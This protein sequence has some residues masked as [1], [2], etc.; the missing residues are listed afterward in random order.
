MSHSHAPERTPRLRLLGLI[1]A[2]TAFL[3]LPCLRFGFV[4]D[5]PILI[6][7]N[8]R[9][10][11]WSF[12]PSYFQHH[13]WFNVS[14]TGSY[15]RPLVLVWLR[16][17]YALF[18]AKPAFWHAS[19]LLVHLAAVIL[20]YFLLHRTFQDTFT[21]AVATAV[22]ALHPAHIE[23]VAWISGVSE[24]LMAVCIFGSLLFWLS[25]REQKQTSFLIA[26][27]AVFATGLL[28]KETAAIAL[29]LVFVYSFALNHEEGVVARSRRGLR[30]CLLFAIVL[31]VYLVARWRVLR[32][33][34]SPAVRPWSAV[35]A[36]LPR[37]SWFYI[38]H[39]FWPVRLSAIYDFELSH[40]SSW[41][42]PALVILA[43]AGLV[44]YTA[45]RSSILFIAL[46]WIVLPLAPAIAGV[47]AFDAHDY[48]HDRYLYLPALGVGLV[49][50]AALRRLRA[51]KR[52]VFGQP[53]ARTMVAILFLAA[54]GYAT[55][56]QL[57]PWT[58]NLT[59]FTRAV[60]V[61][62]RN[63][64]AYEHLAFELYKRGDPMAA[65]N[66]YKKSVS[67]DPDDWHANFGLAVMFY[68]LQNWEGVDVYC[69][70]AN[71]IA[72]DSNNVCY[73]YQTVA[74]MNLGRWEA[75][76]TPIRKAIAI[77]PGLSG[78]H[79]LLGQVLA[80]EGRRDEAKRE[81][82][83]ELQ[84]DPSSQAAKAQLGEL[85]R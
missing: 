17:N 64:V 80:R 74:R 59:L 84:I 33:E 10:T 26:A 9:L 37:V 53:A 61:A 70:R 65:I 78:Q 75:A 5:D 77:W 63:P 72:P 24:P 14:E 4:Y 56:T 6:V 19:T 36:N 44:A 1:V 66:L 68:R 35:I 82:L 2:A 11:S 34:Y 50:A 73:D 23:S 51:G 67:L 20:V 28:V 55:E 71:Q 81:V 21:V 15:Y 76:E 31:A 69:E 13:F 3:Y 79:L 25:Y 62:P 46:A 83:Q 16:L 58:N 48:V 40:S 32:F 47:V 30:D 57:A 41:I 85:Q 8:P 29:A 27:L 38:K 54:L 60:A 39:L 22:F 12:V 43:V 49:L 52:L 45:R 18:G 42:L 7:T